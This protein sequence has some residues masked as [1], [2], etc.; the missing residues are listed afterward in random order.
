M[1]H[2][3][4]ALYWV[5][6]RMLLASDVH[7]GKISHFRKHGSALP[8][9]AIFSNFKKLNS[10]LE[11]FKPEVICFLGDL[12]HSTLNNEWTLFKQWTEL[13]A[14]P[15]ILVAGNHDIISHHKYEELGITV[16]SELLV[17]KFLLTHHPENRD[18]FYTLS[19][20]IHPSIVLAGKGR[21]F[22]KLPCF[23]RMPDQ[24]ILPAFGEFTGSYVMDPGQDDRVYVITKQD[25]IEVN[26]DNQR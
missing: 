19:G 13:T 16:V 9:N 2:C 14:T 25:V 5:E 11:Y 26:L 4:G 3:S 22:L 17:D 15:I 7:L 18:S 1:L 8:E 12:F 6:R 10:V 21:Q 20:H 23:F 24:M